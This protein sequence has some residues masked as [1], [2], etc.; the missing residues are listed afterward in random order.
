[1]NSLPER[2]DRTFAEMTLD[3][4]SN[5]LSRADNPGILGTYLTDEIRELTGTRCV[6]LVEYQKTDDTHA[7]RVVSV[8]PTR[9]R[10]WAESPNAIIVYDFALHLEK[11]QVWHEAEPCEAYMNLKN[12]GFPLSLVIPLRIGKLSIGGLFLFGLPEEYHLDMVID[13]LERLSTTVALVLRNAFLFEQQE[14]IIRIRTRE[15]QSANESI[16]HHERILENV[17]NTIPQSVFWKDRNSTYLGCN[18]A[19]ARSVGIERKEDIAGKTDFDLPWP[20]EHTRAYRADDREVIENKTPKLHIIEPLVLA[21]GSQIFI[22]TSKVPL[23]NDAGTTEGVIGIYENIT[24]RKTAE[25]RLARSERNYREIFNATSDALVIHDETGQFVDVNKRFCEMFGYDRETSLLMKTSDFSSE[26][27]EFSQAKALENIFRAIEVGP[28]VFQWKCRRRDGELLWAEVALHSSTISGEKRVIASIRDITERKQVEQSLINSLEFNRQIIQNIKEGIIVFDNELRYTQ[29]NSFMEQYSGLSKEEVLGHYPYELFPF[30]VEQGMYDLL[31][32]ALSG[33]SIVTADHPYE[34]PLSGKNG[35][36]YDEFFPYKDADGNIIGVIGIVHEITARKEAEEALK[37]SEENLQNAQEIAHIGSWELSLTGQIFWSRELYRI[38]GVSPE[39]FIPDVNSFINIIHPDDRQAMQEWIRA[40]REGEMPGELEFR[41][42]HPDGSVHWI[43]GRGELAYDTNGKP[44]QMTGTAQDI[45]DRKMAVEA[46]RREKE[47]VQALLENMVDGVVV[48]DEEGKLVLFNRTAREW[49]GLDPLEIPQ[50]KWA[51]YYDLFLPDGVTPMSETTVPLARAFRG[52]VLQDA[53]MVIRAK[54]KPIR[55]I[56]SNCS[57]FFNEKGQLLGAVAVMHDITE[58]KVNQESLQRLNRDLR[59]LSSCNQVLVR[60]ENEEVLLNAICRIICDE[61]GYPLAWVGFADPDQNGLIHRIALGGR[62]IR[63]HNEKFTIDAEYE[64][65]QAPVKAVI[66]SRRTI[67]INDFSREEVNPVWRDC[68]LSI[69]YVSTII[70]PLSE[71]N[72]RVFGALSI[73]SSETG[74][75]TTA[76]VRLLEELSGDLSYGISTLRTRKEKARTEKNLQ[77]AFKE[78]ETLLE[79]LYH[80]TKNNMQVISAF[81]EMRAAFTENEELQQTLREMEDRIRVMALVH[82]K[83]YQSQNLSEIDLREYLTDLAGLI[84]KSYFSLADKVAVHVH[85]ESIMVT[86]DIAVPCGLVVMEL[87]TNCFKYAFPSGRTGTIELTQ[88]RLS[89]NEVALE[90]TDDGAGR[91]NSVDIT[92]LHSLGIP[93]AI[94][95]VQRQLRGSITLDT[96]EGFHWKIRFHTDLYHK[97][98]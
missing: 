55:H 64:F 90:L 28:Q 58:S 85:S 91:G 39:S 15:L 16:A 93:M 60:T 47:F 53:G 59:A 3:L 42:I 1:M 50:D 4:L 41:A 72:G 17:L 54:G 52:E 87:L 75:F 10:L 44:L 24:E 82:Q 94:T 43:S 36:S 19:F 76:E 81:I 70:L 83:L 67:I 34:I 30:M 74:I 18:E 56:L 89:E 68:V 12:E 48:C 35:W 61:A 40:C 38:Y 22:D 7:H 32:R 21:D 63:C 78:K 2:S 95:I 51:E 73:Y 6:V 71:D 92:H 37:K 8:N 57:P 79:E 9:K 11:A 20:V 80:R 5:I 86:I 26:E 25:E 69:G 96:S 66:S 27:Q 33:E 88:R 31:K 23:V 62:D 98:I 84:S 65:W 29:W 46:L 13:L 45:T 14:E 77:I 49:H 97:R